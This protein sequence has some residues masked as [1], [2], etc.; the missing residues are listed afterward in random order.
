MLYILK[1]HFNGILLGFEQILAIKTWDIYIFPTS[2]A[3]RRFKWR[4]HSAGP[5][6][7]GGCEVNGM[8]F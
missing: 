6:G 7:G 8:E 4:P 3:P 1:T 5:K 2:M